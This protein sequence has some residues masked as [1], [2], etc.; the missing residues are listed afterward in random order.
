MSYLRDKS[1]VARIAN[2]QFGRIGWAQL[3]QLGIARG[4]IG[5]WRTAGYLF[6]ELPRVY[7]VGSRAGTVE[8]DLAAALLYAGPGAALSHAT[9]AWWLGLIDEQ[10]QTVHVSTPRQCRSL[11]GIRVYGRR[12]RSHAMHRG[13]PVTSVPEILLDVAAT[14][15]FRTLRRVLAADWS[16]R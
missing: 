3:R 4:T 6:P 15:P 5:S 7:A 16:A 2:R 1:R 12:P 14:A 10:S 11:P 9:A 13:L 8:S